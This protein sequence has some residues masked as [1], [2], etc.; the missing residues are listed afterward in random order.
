ML[1]GM[2]NGTETMRF[3]AVSELPR[4]MTAAYLRVVAAEKPNKAEKR[5][6]RYTVGGD[7]ILYDGPVGTLT[8]D[9]TTVKCLLNSVGFLVPSLL[10]SISDFYLDTQL[11]GKEYTLI[12][13]KLIPAC[14]MEQYHL[15]GL[16]HNGFVY[17]EISKGMYSLPQ[18]GILANDHLQA[19]LLDRRYKQATHTPSLFTHKTRLVTFS[20]IVDDFGVKYVGK[21]NAQH[22]IDTLL[23]LYRITIDWTGTKYCGLTLQWNYIART[24]HVSMPGY[25]AKALARFQSPPPKRPQ[26]SPHAYTIPTHGKAVQ[27]TEEADTTAPLDATGIT[28]LQ[29]IIG[30]LLFYARAVDSTMLVAL[31]TLASAQSKGTEATAQTAT[32]LLNYSEL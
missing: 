31:G 32:Q 14:I 27:Y 28:R 6:I 22:L 11:P 29:E 25:V 5:R 12:A 26:H 21:D 10:P 2:L 15:A 9:L 7:K 13:V 8:A 23:L 19:H 1:P 16:V 18:S 4:D 30:V 3:I 17:I 24:V 20:L